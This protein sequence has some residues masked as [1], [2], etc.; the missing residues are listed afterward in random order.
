[1]LDTTPAK[2][3]L[4]RKT[5]S[6]LKPYEQLK[7]YI[8]SWSSNGMI[9]DLRSDLGI[10]PQRFEELF[11]ET[12]RKMDF[13]L[14]LTATKEELLI[15]KKISSSDYLETLAEIANKIPSLSV[16][17][18]IRYIKLA[19]TKLSEC[20]FSMIKALKAMKLL[21]DNHA[22]RNIMKNNR[23]LQMVF[24]IIQ[25]DVVKFLETCPNIRQSPLLLRSNSENSS[26]G[27]S[28]NSSRRSSSNSSHG[29]RP[30]QRSDSSEVLHMTSQKLPS[31]QGPYTSSS[32][33]L[34]DGND[35]SNTVDWL[36][37]ERKRRI[38][39]VLEEFNDLSFGDNVLTGDNWEELS[40]GVDN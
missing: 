1:M 36:S 10:I 4:S 11:A 17:P 15:L 16:S 13:P 30:S 6:T 14:C 26:Q 19:L 37:D 40:F 21:P 2:K 35:N 28:L 34:T 24:E 25:K 39:Q 3:H 12:E 5:V 33:S 32:S 8:N 23:R 18:N 20:Y 29:S 31:S 22:N 9:L 7:E 38:N 27:S